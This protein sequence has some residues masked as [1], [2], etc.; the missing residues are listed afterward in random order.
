MLAARPTRL[1]RLTSIPWMLVLTTSACGVGDLDAAAD[2][3]VDA[4]L[5][6]DA[7]EELPRGCS[8]CS[9][10]PTLSKTY[11]DNTLI[12]EFNDIN[13]CGPNGEVR[14]GIAGEVHYLFRPDGSAPGGRAMIYNC[15]QA[16]AGSSNGALPIEDVSYFMVPFPNH[17]LVDNWK[18]TWMANPELVERIICDEQVLC[19]VKVDDN[20]DYNPP[21]AV[22]TVIVNGV[23]RF[24]LFKNSTQQYIH[25]IERGSL[26]KLTGFCFEDEAYTKTIPQFTHLCYGSN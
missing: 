22:K 4:A 6:P 21:A 1:S 16:A 11:T 23:T 8:I 13:K 5:E 17:P 9:G 26:T 10:A 12:A 14:I 15:E 18:P 20:P 25:L 2:T 7:S 24:R 19:K 3:P